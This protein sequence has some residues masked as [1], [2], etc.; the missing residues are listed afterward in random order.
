MKKGQR[1]KGG[2]DSAKSMSEA[3][4]GADWGDLAEHPEIRTAVQMVWSSRTAL[5][6]GLTKTKVKAWRASERK[7]EKKLGAILVQTVKNE[8]TETIKAMLKTLERLS[9]S[10]MTLIDPHRSLVFRLFALLDSVNAKLSPKNVPLQAHYCSS[11]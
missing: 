5:P 11:M 3:I 2:T 10:G 8:E 1:V 4:D 9:A 7:W 6:T